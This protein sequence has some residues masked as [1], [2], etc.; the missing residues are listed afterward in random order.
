[1]FS[2]L[3]KLLVSAI[4]RERCSRSITTFKS[5][6]ANGTDDVIIRSVF[7]RHLQDIIYVLMMI[8]P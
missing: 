7:I 8:K 2:F 3:Q 1:M 6:A 5:T 4:I